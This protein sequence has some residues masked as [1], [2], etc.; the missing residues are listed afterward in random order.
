MCER[1]AETATPAWCDAE[2]VAR[3]PLQLVGLRATVG[4]AELRRFPEGAL[5][6]VRQAVHRA[7]MRAVG[8]TMSLLRSNGGR[9]EVTV[10]VPVAGRVRPTSPLIVVKL[11]GGLVAQ[12]MHQGPWDTLL[13]A[14]DRLSEWLTARRVAI[15]PLMW[16]EYL[17]GPD[18]AEDPSRWRTRITVP[19]PLT[20]P[21]RSGR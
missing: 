18:Q 13:A 7:G 5:P 11:S 15:V 12:V 8:P 21:V 10:A 14:Y 9:F 6:V 3:R 2:I 19:L 20:T 1:R 16:E 17:I 4:L